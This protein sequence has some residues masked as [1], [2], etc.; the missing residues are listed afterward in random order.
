MTEFYR[1]QSAL[2][3]ERVR[4]RAFFRRVFAL[5]L[6]REEDIRLLSFDEVKAKV[7]CQEGYYLG[8]RTVPVDA[9]VGSV[10]RYQDFD[11]EFLPVRSTT[12]ERW[13]RIDEAFY[14]DVVL[15]PVQ[16]IK[17]G[18]VYFVR[19]GNHRVSVAR[20]K[21]VAF[22]D[23]EVIECRARVP[24]GPDMNADDLEAIGEYTAFLEWS[25]LDQLRPDQ[26][27]RFTIPGGYHQLEEHINVHRYFLGL[28][29]ERAVPLEQAVTSWYDHVYMP[30]V[31]LIREEKVLEKFPHRTEADLYIWIMDHLYFLKQCYGDEVGAEEATEDFAEHFAERS[32]LQALFHRVASLGAKSED[33]VGKRTEVA[34]HD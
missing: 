6:G 17:V 14:E 7:R 34:E 20:D 1:A 33:E 32:L 3:F 4:N 9:I 2:D 24:L 25:K 22:I 19:D 13:R 29:R 16:L 18:E 11:R 21:G 31:A 23:A 26:D 15:P 5:L 28:E 10:G 27:I 30:V 12:K 8:M